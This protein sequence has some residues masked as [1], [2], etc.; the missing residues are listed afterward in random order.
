LISYFIERF[1][2]LISEMIQRTCKIKTL[3]VT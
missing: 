2:R 1:F 3:A